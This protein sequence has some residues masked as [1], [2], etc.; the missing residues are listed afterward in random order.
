MKWLGMAAIAFLAFIVNA[1]WTKDRWKNVDVI[2]AD[3]VVVAAPIQV[4]LYGGDRFLAADIEAIRAS[5]TA[6]DIGQINLR[7]LV[8]AQN[9]ASELNPCHEDN[10]YTANALLTSAGGEKQAAEILNRAIDCRFWDEMPPFYL[11]FNQHF[12]HRDY[13][14]ASRNL[15][16]AAS[17]STIR[18]SSFKKL[19]IMFKAESF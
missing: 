16:L 4:V 11:G 3:R 18:V 14:A 10:Y 5:A 2:Y 8:R 9:V 6:M 1:Y 15:E 12:F 19:A 17:R 13:E 7:Y